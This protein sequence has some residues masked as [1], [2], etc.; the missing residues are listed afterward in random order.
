ML[1]DPGDEPAAQQRQGS[2]QRGVVQQA[3]IAVRIPQ[4]EV[5]VRPAPDLIRERLRGER[6]EQPVSVGDPP[7]RVAELHLVVRRPQ[8]VGVPDRDLLL[9]RPVLVDGLLDPHA[10]AG[11][12]VDGLQHHVGGVVVPDRA[13]DRGVAGHVVREVAAVA[14][15]GEVVLVLER[16][17]HRQPEGRGT[18]ELAL[19]EGARAGTPVLAVVVE[20]V[21]QDAGAARRPRQDGQGRGVRDETDLSDRLHPLDRDQLLE[22]VDRHLGPRQADALQQLVLQLVDVDRLGA[23]DAADVAVLE[24]DQAHA[25][26]SGAL[27][28]FA[29]ALVLH[30]ARSVGHVARLPLGHG[31]NHGHSITSPP[32]GPRVCPT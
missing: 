24:P 18:F 25:V 1:A 4:A 16:R 22:Q 21:A 29:D 28:R 8:G 7:H 6:R 32:L 19:E 23:R 12:R 14:L 3:A 26:C 5:D 10:L 30:L 9:A 15:G 31:H 27:H 17:L 13:V 2:G 20:L 11:E